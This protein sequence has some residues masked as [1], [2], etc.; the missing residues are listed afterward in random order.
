MRGRAAQAKEAGGA[1]RKGARASFQR[2]LLG[3][4]GAVGACVADT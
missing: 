4:V 1:A 3:A 2:G